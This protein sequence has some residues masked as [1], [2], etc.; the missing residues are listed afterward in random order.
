VK[1]TG[2]GGIYLF[3]FMDRF[4][5]E[6]RIEDVKISDKEMKLFKFRTEWLVLKFWELYN[7]EA[8]ERRRLE[9][10][11]RLLLEE[12]KKR[13]MEENWKRLKEAEDAKAREEELKKRAEEYRKTK[14]AGKLPYSYMQHVKST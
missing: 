1:D 5:M 8:E 2:D 7:T 10:E 11:Q 9:E 3:N 4:L 6:R 13:E 12:Q 14:E